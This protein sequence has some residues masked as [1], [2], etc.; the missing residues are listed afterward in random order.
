MMR[1]LLRKQ[2][3]NLKHQIPNKS[4]ARNS[5]HETFGTL[6]LVLRICLGFGASDL[7]FPLL[8]TLFLVHRLRIEHALG[9]YFGPLRRELAEEAALVALVAGGAADLLHFQEDRVGVAIQ[10]DALHLLPVAAFLTLP[11]ELVAAAA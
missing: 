10:I 6:N 9:D 4:K 5:K 7:S 8:Y 11:P 1:S 3:P 2:V